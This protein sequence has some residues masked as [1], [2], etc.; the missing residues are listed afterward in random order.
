MPNRPLLVGFHGVKRSGKDT[1]AT[2]L[3][4]WASGRFLSFKRRGFADVAK[5]AFARQFFPSINMSDA[6]EWVDKFKDHPMAEIQFPLGNDDPL[7]GPNDYVASEVPF[8]Q[9]LAQFAT[10][11]ARLIYGEDHWVDQLLPLRLVDQWHQNFLVEGSIP[12]IKFV[13]DVCAIIDMRFENEISRIRTLGGIN[14]KIRRTVAEEAVLAQDEIH[15]SEMGIPDQEFDY[16]V[17][18]NGTLDDFKKNIWSLAEMLIEEQFQGAGR[19]SR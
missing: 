16:V 3:E 11:G 14:V 19:E 2:Y 12:K 8:R 17:P 7:G 5:L 13:A 4:E 1:A 18:N 15:E 10:E 6:I 9:C